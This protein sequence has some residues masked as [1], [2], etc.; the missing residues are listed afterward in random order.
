LSRA[1]TIIQKA[2]ADGV[3]LTLSPAG[4]I[5]ATGDQE[6]LN[7]WLPALREHKPALLAA[8]APAT[9]EADR[10]GCGREGTESGMQ[11]SV[12]TSATVNPRK[13]SDGVV[14]TD[15]HMRFWSMVIFLVKVAIAAIPAIIIL[16]C[17]FFVLLALFGGT[18][19]ILGGFLR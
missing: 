18:F 17:I 14:I 4:T 9:E 1:H 16:S 6:A 19:K 13:R 12:V 5:K 10:H 2:A 8:L 15:I 11:T 7:R 3:I